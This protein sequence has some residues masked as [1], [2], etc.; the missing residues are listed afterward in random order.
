MLIIPFTFYIVSVFS[1]SNFEMS[2]SDYFNYFGVILTAEFAFLSLQYQLFVT[3][4]D[5]KEMFIRREVITGM[6]SITK[7]YK[8]I[9][10]SLTDAQNEWSQN[11]MACEYSSLNFEKMRAF[12][13]EIS[14]YNFICQQENELFR[15]CYFKSIAN[16]INKLNSAIE[17]TI[18]QENIIILELS[19]KEGIIDNRCRK[20]VEIMNEYLKK[21]NHLINVLN[22]DI[23]HEVLDLKVNNKKIKTRFERA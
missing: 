11:E 20:K 15:I 6:T 21:I 3:R 5:E 9:N 12:I 1:R 19:Q 4:R 18:K 23:N 8:T 13:T 22:K 2:F 14:N 17:K 10:D 16:Q 7:T